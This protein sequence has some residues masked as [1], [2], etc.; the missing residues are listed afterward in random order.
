MTLTLAYTKNKNGNK[1]CTVEY[2]KFGCFQAFVY[3]E[4]GEYNWI[5]IHKSQ[6]T[7]DEKKAVEAYKRFCRKYL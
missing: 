4:L 3:E 6:P 5:V 7:M 2:E 1:K